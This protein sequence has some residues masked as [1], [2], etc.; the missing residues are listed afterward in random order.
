MSLLPFLSRT[1]VHLYET[2]KCRTLFWSPVTTRTSLVQH[3]FLL[4]A[5][6]QGFEQVRFKRSS[7][8]VRNMIIERQKMDKIRGEK[9]R[10]RIQAH[11]E[12]MEKQ[13]RDALQRKLE[14]QKRHQELLEQHRQQKLLRQQQQHLPEQQAA[15]SSSSASA[16]SDSSHSTST[17]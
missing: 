10:L 16:P 1:G 7:G 5:Q 3:T 14:R 15:P 12:R 2:K 4:I 11:R 8:R 13:A 6:P 9:K 17:T